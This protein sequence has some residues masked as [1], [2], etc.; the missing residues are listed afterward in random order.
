MME[1][2]IRISPDIPVSL[3]IFVVLVIVAAVGQFC[4]TTYRHSVPKFVLA[5]GVIAHLALV[6]AL[7][8][9]TILQRQS[10]EV[11]PRVAILVDASRRL[12][13]AS[14]GQSSAKSAEKAVA[15]LLRKFSSA[16][17]ELM[18][19]GDDGPVLLSSAAQLPNAMNVSEGS[20][21]TSALNALVEKAGEPPASVVLVTDG[22]LTRPESSFA[23]SREFAQVMKGIP[24]YGVDVGGASIPDASIRSVTGLGHAVAHQ[25][26]S[27]RVEVSCGGGLRCQQVPVSVR[28]F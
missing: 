2:Q 24:I 3:A 28:E 17:A 19:F 7:L 22:R 8:R 11:G 5:L 16:R 10:R 14:H 23:V 1:T 26:F 4:L 27:L 15:D 12:R 25:P 20:D 9:P 18:V 21:L 6:T 13:L